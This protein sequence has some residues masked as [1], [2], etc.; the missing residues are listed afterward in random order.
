M[1]DEPSADRGSAPFPARTKTK[2]KTP[3]P[4]RA[5]HFLLTDRL[6]EFYWVSIAFDLVLR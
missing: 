5:K 1:D 2:N 6:T 4:R 3:T